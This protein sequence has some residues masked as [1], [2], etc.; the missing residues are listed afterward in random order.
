MRLGLAGA[1]V[2][3]DYA[4]LT[5][6]LAHYLASL[7]I[8]AIVTHFTASPDVLAGPAGEHVRS[9]LGEA[10]IGI[11][12]ASGYNPCLVH[13][14][15]AIRE[16]ELNRLRSAFGAARVLGAEMII[17]GCGS[18]SPA[19]SYGPS[20]ANHTEPTRARLVDSLRRAIP[21]AE[22]SGVILA[23]ECH[24][25]TTLDT[26]EHIREVLEAVDSPWVRANFDP[27]NLIGDLTTLYDN[28]AAMSRM[29]QTLGPYYAASA[30]IKDIAVLPELVLH[31]AE[32]P[33]GE[34]LLDFK[35]FF[36]ICRGLGD[37]ATLIVEHLSVEQVGPAFT[38]VKDA[39][40][41]HGVELEPNVG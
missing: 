31:L 36:D 23:L 4:A 28:G 25:L 14:D 27:V 5:P 10:G 15:D 35:A 1:L 17:T 38:F 11:V 8:R 12:Q 40:R 30:H 29:W 33:P 21:W 9:V 3:R 32:V 18:H 13:P 2:P 22:D 16:P 6:A 39:A 37:G 7:G 41:L 26:P 34:G 19:F 24:V 20:A